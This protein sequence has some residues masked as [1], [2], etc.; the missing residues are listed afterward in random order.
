[1]GVMRQDG[2]FRVRS[3]AVG[4]LALAL[5]YARAVLFDSTDNPAFNTTAPTGAL[6]SSGWTFQG[7]FG[8]YLGTAIA[9]YY[10]L[11]AKHIGGDTNWNFT[12]DGTNYQPIAWYDDPAP[13]SDLRLWRVALRLPR[14]A[15]VYAGTN[16][17]NASMV[18]AGRGTQRGTEVVSGSVTNGW[19][20][21]PGD[22]VQR[23][24]T[25]RVAAI[26]TGG[27]AQYLYA[28]FDHGGGP[29][30]CTVSV[31]DSGG[32]EFVWVDGVWQL[33]GIHYTVDGPYS[34]NATGPGFNAA[35]YDR[36]GLYYP[37]GTNWVAYTDHMPGGFYSSRVSAR[38]EWLTNSI[39][40]FDSNA[41]GLPDWWELQHSGNIHG[42]SPTNDPDID[43]QDNLAEWIALTDPTNAASVFRVSAITNGSNQVALAFTGWSNRFYRVWQHVA[44]LTNGAWSLAESNAFAGADGVTQWTDTNSLPAVTARFYRVEVL[45]P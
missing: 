16:E 21:G 15:P 22:G 44:P 33:A 39:P 38:Y 4:V 43:T 41:N 17:V 45:L 2:S 30:E 1:M 20:W 13:G 14:Y 27:G 26:V 18:G 8:S 28:T 6:A 35:I 7:E 12:M 40:D 24:G 29:D 10:F 5:P 32:G 31:G 25:N 11:S 34:T 36:F 23:W 37:V 42:M 9:P 19:Q 3:L